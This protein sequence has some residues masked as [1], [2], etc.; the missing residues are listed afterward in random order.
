[1]NNDT[2]VHTELY[3]K[4]HCRKENE[5]WN[6]NIVNRKLMEIKTRSLYLLT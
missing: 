2:T 4:F 3:V 1:M 5:L 6:S